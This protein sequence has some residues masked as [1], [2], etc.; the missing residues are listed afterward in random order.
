MDVFFGFVESS[1][2][3][4][5][6]SLSPALMCACVSTMCKLLKWTQFHIQPTLMWFAFYFATQHVHIPDMISDMRDALMI[7]YHEIN[8]FGNTV[9]TVYMHISFNI[10]KLLTSHPILSLSSILSHTAPIFHCNWNCQHCELF[11]H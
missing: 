1:S 9:Y 11:M 6:S 5:S 2:S 3:S 4:L 10:L 8:P 7:A